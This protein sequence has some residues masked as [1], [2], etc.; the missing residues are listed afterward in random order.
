MLPVFVFLI[1]QK[2]QYGVGMEQKH[3]PAWQAKHTKFDVAIIYD[4][5]RKLH[6]RQAMGDEVISSNTPCL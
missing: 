1:L 2:A 3:G 6:G 5:G 4:M